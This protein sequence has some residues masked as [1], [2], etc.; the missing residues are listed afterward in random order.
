M[1]YTHRDVT[2]SQSLPTGGEDN[3][4][5]TCNSTVLVREKLHHQLTGILM[6]YLL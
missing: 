2:S 6:Y 5:I 3:S 1:Y 4:A